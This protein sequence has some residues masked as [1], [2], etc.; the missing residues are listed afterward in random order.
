MQADLWIILLRGEGHEIG[1]REEV[2]L[3]QSQQ[4]PFQKRD[5][6]GSCQPPPILYSQRNKCLSPEG[7]SEQHLIASITMEA[8]TIVTKFSIFKSLSGCQK[9][10]MCL[11][12][13]LLLKEKSVQFCLYPLV[14]SS[15]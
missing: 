11:Y 13:R 3:M 5:S 9:Y 10:F 12:F 8:T 15:G 14:S 4:K 1:Q 6:A 7:E 2:N